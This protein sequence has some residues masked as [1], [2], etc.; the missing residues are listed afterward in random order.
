MKCAEEHP[1]HVI[2]KLF[3]LANAHVDGDHSGDTPS[4]ARTDASKIILNK[5]RAKVGTRSIVEQMEQ[6][7]TGI[8]NNMS[9]FKSAP[10]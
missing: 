1:H 7:C 8:V 10:R 9:F 4:P 5:L 6:M 3:A 2:M